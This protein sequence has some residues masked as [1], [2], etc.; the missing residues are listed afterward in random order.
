[1]AFIIIYPIRSM[2]MRC[3]VH[4]ID[5]H[6]CLCHWCVSSSLFI[7]LLT[8]IVSQSSPSRVS[9]ISSS[10]A[11]CQTHTHFSSFAS[12]YWSSSWTLSSPSTSS[13][14]DQ[15]CSIRRLVPVA[16]G[17]L[18]GW[19]VTSVI[20]WSF[21]PVLSTESTLHVRMFQSKTSTYTTTLKLNP[22]SEIIFS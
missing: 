20:S 4:W 13:E 22:V 11:T 1:M 17:S 14:E 18:N 8:F 9:R 5:C 15:T 19:V 3:H 10:E 7:W 2:S 16:W 6:V 12:S 21:S